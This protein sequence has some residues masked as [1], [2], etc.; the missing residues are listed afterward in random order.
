MGMEEIESKEE[1]NQEENVRKKVKHDLQSLTTF[2]EEVP[3]EEPS[4]KTKVLQILLEPENINLKTEL[5]DREIIELA[6]LEVVKDKINS[7]SLDL[8]LQSFKELRV[9]KN[10]QGRKEIVGA[11]Q[12]DDVKKSQGFFD[13]FVTDLVGK[14]PM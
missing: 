7:P 13:Q 1:I 12:D 11:A 3:E 2:E 14:R 4:D 5:I 8:F 6:R 10:R 9:S